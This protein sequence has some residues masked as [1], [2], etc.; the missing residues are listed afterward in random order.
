ML[1][2]NGTDYAWVANAGGGGGGG[3]TDIV[4]DTTPQLGGDLDGQAF[5]ITTTGKIRI[6]TYPGS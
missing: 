1:S 6:Q 3:I 4:N 2:W 5:N